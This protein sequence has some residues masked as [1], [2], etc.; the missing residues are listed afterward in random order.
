MTIPQDIID[1]LKELRIEEVADKLGIVVKLHRAICFMHDDHEPSLKFIPSKN[2]F[3]CFVCDKGGGPIQLV[4]EHEG[5][6][7]QEACFWL[8]KEFNIIIPENK[9]YVPRRVVRR[10][11]VPLKNKPIETYKEIDI[12]IGEWLINHAG[13]SIDA[14]KFLFNTRGYRP[15]IVELLKIASISDSQT[16]T[17]KLEQTFGYDRCKKSGFFWD[18]E[19][20]TL[21]YDSPCLLFPFYTT[22][23]QLYSIQSRY[24]GTDSKTARFRFPKDVKQG[25]FNAPILKNTSS[26]DRLYISEGIT[27]CIA[28]LS[29]GKKAVAFPGAGI[30]HSEDV[31]LLVNKNLYM[32][33]DRDEAGERLYSKLNEILKPY[34]TGVRRLA[35]REGCKDYSDMY[36]HLMKENE[37]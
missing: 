12:E 31:L 3:F 26:S 25:I 34:A 15:E 14:G 37:K 24:I 33:P 22:D 7:F 35:L 21:I 16:I 4:M 29:A 18:N 20:L 36:L 1:R 13:L 5:W 17:K 30:H 10:K 28:L 2:M 6:N 23:G 32:Y 27:D 9:G 11:P 8:A 19:R